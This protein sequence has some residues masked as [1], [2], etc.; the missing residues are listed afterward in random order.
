VPRCMWRLALCVFL[1]MYDII[2]IIIIIIIWPWGRLSLWQKWVPGGY[3]WG[4]R[5]RCVRLTTLP[6]SCA[7]VLKSVSLNFLEPS[8]P[9]QT[10]NGTDYYY[11]YYYHHHH[12]YHHHHYH[13]HH[14]LF[15]VIL[16]SISE[17]CCERR[18]YC[19]ET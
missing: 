16:F 14:N 2:I 18:I 4:K 6:P 7:V 3:P 5:G 10:C 15:V 17:L 9:L 13:H 1:P 19:I 8:G 12:H 11:Y